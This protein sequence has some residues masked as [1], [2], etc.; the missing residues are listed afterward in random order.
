MRCKTPQSQTEEGFQ[1]KRGTFLYTHVRAPLLNRATEYAWP[2]YR[3][4]TP[5]TS[6]HSVNLEIPSANSTWGFVTRRRSKPEGATPS[7]ET[8]RA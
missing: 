1:L 7:P 2:T 8:P 6:A 3:T 4:D 5:P